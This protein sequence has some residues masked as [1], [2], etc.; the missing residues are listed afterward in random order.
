MERSA[1]SKGRQPR[2]LSG[3]ALTALQAH[4]WPGNIW[5]LVNVIERILLVAPVS[6][7]DGV[8]ANDI[9]EAIGQETGQH[10]SNGRTMEVMNLPLRSAREEFEK[11]Y[12]AFQLRRFDGN[13][14]KT[15]E[16]V[17]MDRAALHRK[18]K[19]LGVHGPSD[20]I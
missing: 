8:S 20:E 3:E 1:V 5:E 10:A 2:R 4:D 13:I 16:F 7:E 12:L 18:L 17:G 6:H 19:L 11:E 14:S 9:M 15:A